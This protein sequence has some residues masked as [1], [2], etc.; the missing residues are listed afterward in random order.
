MS[1]NIGRWLDDNVRKYGEYK[2]FIF[3]GPE[4]EKSW[5]NKQILENAR[6]LASGLRSAMPSP[7]S[8]IWRKAAYR[9]VTRSITPVPRASSRRNPAALR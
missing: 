3:L 6:A 9:K 7:R 2:Q 8:K 1:N 5:S 4:G